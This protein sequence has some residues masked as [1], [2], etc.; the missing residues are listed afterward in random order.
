VDRVTAVTEVFDPQQVS[1][2]QWARPCNEGLLRPSQNL[3]FE[4]EA[5]PFPMPCTCFASTIFPAF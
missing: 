3:I 5:S 4:F 1:Y 2:T